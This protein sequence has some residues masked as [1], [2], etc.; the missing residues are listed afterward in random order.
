[1]AQ[2][3]V[4]FLNQFFRIFHVAMIIHAV[5]DFDG[6]RCDGLATAPFRPRLMPG[7]FIFHIRGVGASIHPGSLTKTPPFRSGNVSEDL[8]RPH[9]SYPPRSMSISG[10]MSP[11]FSMV[12]IMS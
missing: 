5:T 11:T 3:I 10:L 8:I 12:S 1:M 7:P 6:G 2:T 4:G 9:S